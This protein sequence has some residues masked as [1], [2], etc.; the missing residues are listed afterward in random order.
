MAPASISAAIG[1][2]R[3][4]R[5]VGATAFGRTDVLQGCRHGMAGRS[6]RRR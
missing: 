6:K 1:G 5:A 4:E 2:A 3:A